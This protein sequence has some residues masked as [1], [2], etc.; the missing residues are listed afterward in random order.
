V[1][2]MNF[3]HM[4]EL[5]WQAGYPLALGAMLVASGILYVVFK[6]RDWL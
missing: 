2:G 5:G 1:Y 3:Q 4:P 6:R